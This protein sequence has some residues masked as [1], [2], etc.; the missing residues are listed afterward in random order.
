MRC[1]EVKAELVAYLDGEVTAEMRDGIDGHLASCPDCRT[2]SM[3]LESTGDLLRLIGGETK[4]SLDIVGNV[5][6]ISRDGDPWCRHIQKEL[7]AHLDGELS[8]AEV[9]PVVEHLA[10]CADCR[11]V[12]DDLYASGALLD[13]WTFELPKVDL[14]SRVLPGYRPRRSIFR[15]SSLAAAACL[16][17][18]VGVAA[19]SGA[20]AT[21]E[22][23][24][25]D[26]LRCMDILDQDTLD[27]LDTLNVQQDR[28]LI[29][30]ADDLEWLESMDDAELAL[31]SGPGD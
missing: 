4:S 6:K 3:A 2:E 31:L 18:A 24:P 12:R 19:L 1:I 15:I 9:R 27:M 5:L 16:L 20:F 10:D 29:E 25:D 13:Q 26:L 23:P 30:I 14:V 28:E 11:A 8:E 7:T 22:P 17:L 21:S